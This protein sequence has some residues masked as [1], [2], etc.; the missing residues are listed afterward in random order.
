MIFMNDRSEQLVYSRPKKP[1][2]A[3]RKRVSGSKESVQENSMENPGQHPQPSWIAGHAILGKHLLLHTD[4][5]R[6]LWGQA[7]P[8]TET[9]LFV[10]GEA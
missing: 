2:T 10:K 9:A 7:S 8:F 3:V 6:E 4:T 5:G 1:G